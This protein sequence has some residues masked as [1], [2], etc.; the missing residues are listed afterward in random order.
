MPGYNNGQYDFQQQTFCLSWLT[1]LSFNLTGS[2]EEIAKEF[3]AAME[4]V[5]TDSEIKQLIGTWNIVWGPGVF[6]DS[7]GGAKKKSL[8]AMFIAAPE[9]HPEQVVISISGTNG[10]SLMNWLVEDFNVSEKVP[11]PYGTSPL[12]PE[13]SKGIHFGLS[14]LVDMDARSYLAANPSITQ[15]MVTGHSLGGALSPTYALY[16][17]ET[18]SAWDPS[19]STTILCLPTAGQTPGDEG[20]SKYYDDRLLS[21]TRV[22]NSLDIV[23]HAF[24]VATLRQ[25]P[26]I[27]EPEIPAT[28]GIETLA[29]TLQWIVRDL[30][31]LNIS[32]QTEGFPSQLIN[33]DVLAG[34]YKPLVEVLEALGKKIE[35]GLSPFQRDLLG[36]GVI[37]IQD[38]LQHTIAYI[39]HFGI[40]AFGQRMSD[41]SGQSG[42]VHSSTPDFVNDLKTSLASSGL[43]K[44]PIVMDL[45]RQSRKKIKQLRKGEGALIEDV[46]DTIESLKADASVEINDSTQVVIVVVEQKES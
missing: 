41:I 45:G 9:T 37:I 18:R 26:T 8:N 13:L 6:A 40:D 38:L 17:D 27:Y 29:G 20:F 22:W 31:Y 14:K 30:N 19:G 25:V 44:S 28:Q 36:S 1:S 11:W 3:K 42:F 2:A 4:K 7:L 10:S 43:S 15:V 24:N 16:L 5:L 35:N 34:K 32:P 39:S 21:T 23:P 33:I 46:A 12:N